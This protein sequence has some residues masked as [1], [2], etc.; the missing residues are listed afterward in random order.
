MVAGLVAPADGLRF[1]VQKSIVMSQKIYTLQSQA[2]AASSSYCNAY[3][4]EISIH[5]YTS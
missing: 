5:R 2:N 3:P 4:T 1:V